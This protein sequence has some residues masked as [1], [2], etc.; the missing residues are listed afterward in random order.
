MNALPVD[1]KAKQL[2]FTRY[3]RN[4]AENP[5]PADVKTERIAMYREL[6]FNNIDSFLA[7]NFPVIR[8]ILSDADWYAL[9]QDFFA[10]HTCHTPYFSEIAG[11][12]LNYLQNERADAADY[13]FLLELAHYEWVEMAL[14]IAKEDIRQNALPSAD[15]AACMV[16]LSPLAWPLIYRY[17]VQQI[18]PG[19]L[20]A[21]APGEPTCLIAYRDLNDE[22]KFAEINAM[23]YRMLE[24]IQEHDGM[25]IDACL[26]TLAEESRHPQ[27]ESIMAGGLL[28]LQEL[29]EK[30]VV[31]IGAAGQ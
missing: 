20:P 11:E 1:F 12:F 28:I 8:T 9:I 3:I 4:P 26:R 23:T 17:P 6:I 15:F 22:V 13:P 25:P 7:N 2:E 5:P 27:P 21:E 29:A 30:H 19:F 16:A 14:S 18:S 31:L 10:R 24:I